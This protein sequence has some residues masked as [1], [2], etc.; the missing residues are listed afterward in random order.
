[1]MSDDYFMFHGRRRIFNRLDVP[2]WV[3]KSGPK[4]TSRDK[5]NLRIFL[6]RLHAEHEC[7]RGTLRAIARGEIEPSSNSLESNV[8]QR[9]LNEATRRVLHLGRKFRLEDDATRAL[10]LDRAEDIELLA[11]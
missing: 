7:L 3:M 4:F 8:L 10:A 6:L 9:Y 5:N 1:Q 11:Q 2:V